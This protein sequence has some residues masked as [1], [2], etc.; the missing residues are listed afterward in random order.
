[1]ALCFL[2]KIVICKIKEVSKVVVF[3]TLLVNLF[4]TVCR[5]SGCNF[6]DVLHS[7]FFELI[8]DLA[9]GNSRSIT[10]SNLKS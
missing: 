10:S 5:G 7:T 8:T 2:T 9:Y 6:A 1:M 4:G 3:V